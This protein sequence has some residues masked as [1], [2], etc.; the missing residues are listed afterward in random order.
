MIN[1]LIMGG[2]GTGKTECAK[3]L[4][5]RS[6]IAFVF[7]YQNSG[8]WNFLPLFDPNR[9]Q[10]KCRII[11]DQGYDYREFI[12]LV[13]KYYFKI[14]ATIVLEESK[15]LF[16]SNQ[17]DT[18]VN[19]FLLSCR[20]NAVNFVFL[21]HGADQ[22]PPFIL[23]YTDIVVTKWT[24]GNV[25]TLKRKFNNKV[26][27]CAIDCQKNTGRTYFIGV[28]NKT[29]NIFFM[30]EYKGKNIHEKIGDGTYIKEIQEKIKN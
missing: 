16:D 18:E 26:F 14:G 10:A 8:D 21:F 28:S 24:G 7:D 2:T 12:G 5:D 30:Q 29:S 4:V 27:N 23:T 13:K 11:K 9:F 22:I 25:D 1:T 15:G 19:D 20:H 3:D 6:K 17:L